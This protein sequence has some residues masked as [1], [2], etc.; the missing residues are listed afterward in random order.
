LFVCLFL[1]QQTP[2]GTASS[3]TRFLDHTR[4]TTVGRTPADQL[5]AET[6]T[7]QQTTFN[8]LHIQG[9]GGIRTQIPAGERPQTYDLDRAATAKGP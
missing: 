8:R 1:A 2:V 3:F 4:R 6:S 7:W 5:V 9:S